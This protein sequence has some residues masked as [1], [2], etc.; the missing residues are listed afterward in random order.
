MKARYERE[1]KHL[2]WN[3]YME[4]DLYPIT[5]KEK[6]SSVRAKK[7][8]ASRMV[9][10]NL[11]AS[12]AKRYF[13]QLVNANFTEKDIH[14]SLTYNDECVPQTEQQGAHDLDLYLR[15]LRAACRKAELPAPKFV[16][17]T[18][19][20]E[21][22]EIEAAVRMHHHIILSCGLSRD[23]LEQLWHRGKDKARLGY[24]NAD[25]LQLDKQ[26][27]ERLANYL[28]KYTNRKR[29]WR[30]S[31]GLRKPVRP[32]PNDSRWS[33]R[34]VAQLVRTG[35]VYDPDFWA[36][37]YPGWLM[38]EIETKFNEVTGEWSIF[39]K[40]RRQNPV[41]QLPEWYNRRS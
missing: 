21:A 16:A 27:L 25:R 31:R 38:N 41:Q 17:V 3:N 15:R 10:Q 18:E 40:M 13:I 11:N 5:E 2:C 19:W 29:R 37:K 35:K 32:R 7:A 34:K 12:H 1:Q 20:R 39:L 4:V 24:A 26:S 22:S 8:Q 36:A 23:T 9:Q 33:R 6:A 28:T 14:I 30:Q